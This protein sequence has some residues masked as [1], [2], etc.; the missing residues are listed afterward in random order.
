MTNAFLALTL[1]CL[2]TGC[3]STPFHQQRWVRSE[4]YFGLSK[5]DGSSISHLEWESFV[6]E[7]VTPRFPFGLSIVDAIGQWQ[8]SSGRIER[9][10]SK[11]LVLL[12]PPSPRFEADIDEIRAAYRY[13]F[14]QEAVM[15]VTT[16]AR[17]SF[18]EALAKR[19]T[20]RTPTRFQ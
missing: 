4:I 17:V 16:P 6:N 7:V 3:Q 5:P 8:N 13:R 14:D 18:R 19:V 10:S 2:L 11:V 12:H 9:E 1:A 15:K 20:P